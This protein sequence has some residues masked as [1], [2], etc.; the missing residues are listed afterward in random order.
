MKDNVV[1]ITGGGHTSRRRAKILVEEKHRAVWVDD[2]EIRFI[3]CAASPPTNVVRIYGTF[4]W[5]PKISGGYNVMQAKH[6]L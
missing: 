5:K 2:N 3:V 1:S 4:Y 6:D